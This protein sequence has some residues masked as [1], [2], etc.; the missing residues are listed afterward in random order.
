MFS[1][2]GA[3]ILGI[4]VLRQSWGRPGRSI[5][6]NTAGWLLLVAGAI[7]GW[8][9]AGA[10]GMAVAALVATGIAGLVLALAAFEKP[11]AIRRAGVAEN[12]ATSA[13]SGGWHR[14]ILT[15]FL[16]GPMALIV[17]VAVALAVRSVAIRW[18]LA[19]ADA[20]VMVLALVPLVWPLLTCAMLMTSN[21]RPQIAMLVVPLAV[22][23]VPL[24][25]LGGQS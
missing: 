9:A 22:A 14:G 18:P 15:F 23:L 5:L 25:L 12:G 3:A 21:R 19:K 17:A 6:R 2:A 1:S 24:F 20:N 11:K 7:A 10:W 13:T 8:V 16:T 4:V